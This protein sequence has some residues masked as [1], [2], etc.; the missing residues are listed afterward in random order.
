MDYALDSKDVYDFH[1]GEQKTIFKK[2]LELKNL[3][4]SSKNYIT[5][6]TLSNQIS[7]MQNILQQTNPW[8]SIPMLKMANTTFETEYSKLLSKAKTE[9][10]NTIKADLEC[11]QEY[12]KQWSDD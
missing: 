5:G 9:E 4:E 1:K 3:Y 12:L 10:E 6:D 8:S 11:V 7:N 2:S